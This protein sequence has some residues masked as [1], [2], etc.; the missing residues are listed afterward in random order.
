MNKETLEETV[1]E[2]VGRVVENFFSMREEDKQ[3]Y[4][5]LNS[6]SDRGAAILAAEYFDGR[7]RKAIKT[8]FESLDDELRERLRENKE[9]RSRFLGSTFRI[10][11]NIAYV[12]GIYNLETKYRL[13][14]VLEIR[15]KF[16]HPSVPELIDFNTQCVVVKCAKFSLK[17]PSEQQNSRER[18]IRYLEEVGENVWSNLMELQSR[19]S[20]GHSE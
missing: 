14:D 20:Q 10:R 17:D 13:L 5:S 3:F 19:V 6:E 18:Y 12:L 15:N 1:K 2:T 11:I 7:L 16:A 8:K 9:I 4:E